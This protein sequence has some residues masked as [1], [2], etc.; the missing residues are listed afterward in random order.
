[1]AAQVCGGGPFL[2]PPDDVL[3]FVL[4]DG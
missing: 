1:V 2:A 4:T 3:A